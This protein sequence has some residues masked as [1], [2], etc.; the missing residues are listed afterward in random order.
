MEGDIP[1]FIFYKKGESAAKGHLYIHIFNKKEAEIVKRHALMCMAIAVMV[2]CGVSIVG[3]AAD[4]NTV[5]ATERWES[6]TERGGGEGEWTLTKQP[7]GQ[8]G[9]AGEWTYTGTI[10]CPFNEGSVV[11]EGPSFS[12]TAEGTA[13]NASA[14]PGY[15]TSSFTLKVKG[16]T[17]G[18]EASGTYSI[19]FVVPEWPR[20]FSG[21]WTAKRT[22][23]EGIT[24]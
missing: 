12:F 22:A 4:D 7:D 6:K 24:E 9:I 3:Y 15:Q 17:R 11:M 14:P 1:R 5:A 10:T 19:T 23:G 2:I 20:G 13:T 16:V 18:G 21:K 8:L